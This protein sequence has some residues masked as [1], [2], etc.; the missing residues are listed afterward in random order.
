ML[1]AGLT[2]GTSGNV[3][4]RTAGGMLIT[5]SAV[6]FE[7]LEPELLLHVPLVSDAGEPP[8]ISGLC[9]STEWRLHAAIL[10][11]R[12]EVGAVLHAHPPYATALACMR[13][14]IPSFHYMVAVAGGTDIRCAAYATFGT[15]ELA[16]AALTALESRTACLLA[17]HGSVTLGDTPARALAL[18]VE[19]EALAQQYC[20]ALA[21][22]EPALLSSAEM[23]EVMQAFRRYGRV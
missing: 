19:V 17:N 4:A 13:R 11:A 1:D 3:S 20:L 21:A 16:S 12:P 6:P 8:A 2:R 23:A 5:P 15:P 9:V 7:Q 22:G 10:R 14:G 18:A